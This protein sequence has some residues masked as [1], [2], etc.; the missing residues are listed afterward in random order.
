MTDTRM[1]VLGLM[2]A[3]EPLW[4]SACEDY[5][6]GETTAIIRAHLEL[7]R[8]AIDPILERMETG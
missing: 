5:S 4:Q 2:A 1:D 7:H 8:H 3:A 6:A